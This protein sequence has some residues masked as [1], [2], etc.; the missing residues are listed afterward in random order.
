MIKTMTKKELLNI[1]KGLTVYLF[2][3]AGTIT[4]AWDANT[5]PDLAGYKIHYGVASGDYTTIIDVKDQPPV[6]CPAPYDPFKTEC[7]E[8]TLVGFELGKTYYFAATA[9]DKDNN[10]SAYSEEL[11][12]IFTGDTKI[13]MDQPKNIKKR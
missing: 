1:L 8:I 3:L 4:L 10:E 2:S 12:H 7:C 5:E 11:M 9:Y 6:N 13:R